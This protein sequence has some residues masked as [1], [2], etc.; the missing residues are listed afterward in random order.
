MN[1]FLLQFGELIM[2]K[3]DN[4]VFDITSLLG[5]TPKMDEELNQLIKTH[6][7]CGILPH[8]F[9]G[10]IWKYKA[11]SHSNHSVYIPDS[12]LVEKAEALLNKARLYQDMK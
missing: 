7:I 9:D 11:A 4:E 5:W 3:R 2:Q 10:K 6:Q 12:E 8:G 1:K